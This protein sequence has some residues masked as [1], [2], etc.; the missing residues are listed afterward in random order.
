MA[1][2][3]NSHMSTRLMYRA[4]KIAEREH[5]KFRKRPRENP[6][7]KV[8]ETFENRCDRVIHG[9]E[10]SMAEIEDAQNAKIYL[11]NYILEMEL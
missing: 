7:E 4:E 5:E 10:S 11:Q 8:L 9:N 2:R 3:E 6:S 1:K